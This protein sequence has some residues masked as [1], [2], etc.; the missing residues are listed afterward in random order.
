MLAVRADFYARCAAYPTLAK[1]LGANH[2]L[3]GPM[4]REELRRAIERPAQRAGLIV[5]PEL[6]DALVA[7]VEDEPGALPLLSTALLELWQ[8]RDGRHLLHATYERTG[9]VRGAVARLAE[10]AFGQLDPAQQAVARRVLLR[11]AGEGTGG[12]V[13]RRRVALAELEGA[14]GDDLA[15]VLALLT[16]RRLLTMSATTV[17]VAH[18]ALLREWPRLRDWLE[19]D[20][21]GRRVHRHLADAAREWDERGRA[22][23]DLYG[24]ARLAAALEWRDGHEHELNAT[25]RAFLDASRTAAGR[26]QRRLRLALAGVAALLVVAALGGVVALHQRGTARSEARAAEA[27]RLG[28]QALIEQRLDRSLLLARQG[29]A[30][31]DSRVTRSNLLAALLRNPAAIGV[32]G[33]ARGPLNALGLSPDGR[34]L[35]TADD[36]GRVVFLDPVTRRPRGR[37]YTALTPI[38]AVTYSPDGRVLALTGDDFIDVLDGRTHVYRRRLFAARAVGLDIGKLGTGPSAFFGT[39]AFSPDSRVLAADV[40]VY[41]PPRRHRALGRRH[42]APARPGTAGCLD[43]GTR[44]GRL[45]RTREAAGDLWRRP[46]HGRPR[47]RHDAAGAPASAAAAFLTRSAPTGVALALGGADGSVRLLDLQT[48]K[49]RAT[50]GRHDAAVTDVRFTPDSRTLVT[51]GGD[52]RVNVWSV[53]DA[54]RIDTFAGHAGAVSGIAISPDGRTVYSAGQDG[55]VVEWDLTGARRLG[56][57]FTTPPT[58]D[59]AAPRQG[60]A[61]AVTPDQTRFAVPDTAGRVDVLDS[62]TLTPDRAHPGQPRHARHRGGAGT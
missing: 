41:P 40:V 14:S 44:S 38:F 6:V 27:Q 45:P 42:R 52:G 32:I 33:G 51:A 15:R 17:E 1:L 24:G 34:T 20:A 7:D 37:P 26:A 3:V 19:E 29:V 13:V 56:R 55:N 39:V 10:E 8:R 49:L 9:G 21:D 23:G 48:G 5:E 59:R 2:V 30:L 60:F 53:T 35:A 18:E 43:C 16:D 28:A 57:S 47:R 12:T 22:P 46:A 25:E 31:D 58:E 54:T 62:R 4:E 50:A 36:Q 11:L 61:V